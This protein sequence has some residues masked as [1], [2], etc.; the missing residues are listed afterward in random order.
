MWLVLGWVA[1]VWVGTSV[2]S[3]PSVSP[4]Y[5]MPVPICIPVGAFCGL[6]EYYLAAALCPLVLPIVGALGVLF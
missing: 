5:S 3:P 4:H 1:F 2:V 6:L